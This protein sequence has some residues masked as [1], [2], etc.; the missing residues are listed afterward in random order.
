MG[1]PKTG[2]E[3]VR[4][5][6]V[7]RRNKARAKSDRDRDDAEEKSTEA[8]SVLLSVPTD[9]VPGVGGEVFLEAYPSDPYAGWPG[10]PWKDLAGPL[11]ET[12]QAPRLV[13]AEASYARV[14]LA[15]AAGCLELALDAANGIQPRNS[16][17]KMLA[18]QLAACHEVAMTFMARAKD[19][20]YSVDACRLAGTA[21]RLVRTF[22]EGAETL[23]RIRTGGRQVMTVQHVHVAEGGQA[24]VAGSV[25][26]GGGENGGEES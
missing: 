24:V 20:E 23:A 26:T 15:H 9:F 25:G 7:A 16:V 22:Q 2:A 17:E 10:D 5:L 8:L 18:H 14:E 11:R 4:A 3:A 21:A 19:E 13:N 6:A 12:I 1:K